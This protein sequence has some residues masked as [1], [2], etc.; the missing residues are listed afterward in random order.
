V[1]MYGW[2]APDDTFVMDIG[3]HAAYDR[4]QQD[5]PAHVRARQAQ[6]RPAI[7]VDRDGVINRNRQDY[8]KSWA[9]FEFLPGAIEALRRLSQT[10]WPIIVVSNQSAVGRGV[11]EPQVVEDIH[12]RMAAA[13]RRA[14]GRVDDVLYCPHAPE[15]HCNCRKP[16]PGLFHQAAERHNIDL[17]RS[18]MIGDAACDVE[19]A[20]AAGCKPVLVRS[21]RWVEQAARL[22]THLLDIQHVAAGLAEGADW[23]VDQIAASRKGQAQPPAR[24]AGSRATGAQGEPAQAAIQKM[25]AP[26]GAQRVV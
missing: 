7:F 17:S 18:Y 5:W 1:S 15:E 22:R 16:Q 2:A 6:P 21:G 25:P 13:I 19:A 26:F 11:V 10:G 14:G 3:S 9:E 20:C 12:A 24:I 8:V 4:A 23:V